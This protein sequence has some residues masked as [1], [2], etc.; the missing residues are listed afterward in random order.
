[1]LAMKLRELFGLSTSTVRK[2]TPTSVSNNTSINNINT[3]DDNIVYINEND[4]NN[5]IQYNIENSIKPNSYYFEGS[6]ILIENDITTNNLDNNIN[7]IN[8]KTNLDNNIN[9]INNKTNLN[10]NINYINNKNNILN[11]TIPG[12]VIVYSK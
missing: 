11:N 6:N 9:Y 4:L 5:N 12:P 7:Y 3:L 8:N 10:N 1:M 2:S